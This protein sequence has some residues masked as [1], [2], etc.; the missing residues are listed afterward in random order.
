MKRQRSILV[1]DDEPSV[2]EMI[3]EML[4]PLYEEVIFTDS[5]QYARE[6]IQKRSFSLI[7]S[8]VHIPQLP[9]PDFV[10]LVRALGRLDPIIFLTGNSTKD[11]VL[12]ALRLGVA[13]VIDKPFEPQQFIQ[14][15]EHVFEIE[16]RRNQLY[17]DR[18]K[19]DISPLDLERQKK[20]LGLLHVVS[21]KKSG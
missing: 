7:I 2:G 3:A 1:F 6:L 8:D 14:S 21:E 19:A 17:Q 10:R 13:D 15:I 20:M 11:L 18:F 9:G 5:A 12:T 4:S 16:K